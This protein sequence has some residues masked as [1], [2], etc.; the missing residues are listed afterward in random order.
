MA[1]IVHWPPHILSA[2]SFS[3][4]SSWYLPHWYW[5][6]L[7]AKSGISDRSTFDMPSLLADGHCPEY[8]AVYLSDTERV[9]SAN[10][11]LSW[12]INTGSSWIEHVTVKPWSS[13]L[14]PLNSTLLDANTQFGNSQQHL[15][16]GPFHLQLLWCHL[17]ETEAKIRKKMNQSVVA[18][19]SAQPV[20]IQEYI[21]LF[22]GW[23][24]DGM[25]V[26]EA[27]SSAQV[28]MPK[29]PCSLV[30]A[31]CPSWGP[32]LWHW[33]QYLPSSFWSTRF[34]PH[35]QP[36]LWRRPCSACYPSASNFCA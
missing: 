28:L 19:S 3:E 10:T 16:K 32:A 9:N 4:V 22:W 13:G 6:I 15:F 25:K 1:C 36:L 8:L 23:L 11:V 33:S 26:W 14:L 5:S 27:P 21:T 34:P 24:F 17:L 12:A 35:L 18:T 2:I 20:K 31:G 30:P 29:G 7:Q